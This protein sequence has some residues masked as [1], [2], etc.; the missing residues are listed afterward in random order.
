MRFGE[1]P[2]DRRKKLMKGL[3]KKAGVHYFNF[4]A[5]RHAGASLMENNGVPLGSIQRILDMKVN[6]QLRYTYT[7]LE[8]RRGKPWKFSSGC[9]KQKSHTD[10]HTVGSLRTPPLG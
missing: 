10:S 3:C 6:G 7:L 1:G 5:L 9:P 2:Y 8:E 4:H